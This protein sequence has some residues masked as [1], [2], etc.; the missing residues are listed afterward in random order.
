MI[1]DVAT[2]LAAC[3]HVERSEEQ[4]DL[5]WALVREELAEM[6]EA[7]KNHDYV[8]ELDGIADTIWVLIGYA[9]SKGYNLDCAWKEV[10]RSNHAKI[11]PDGTVKRR[12]DNKIL[13]P[14]GWTPPNIAG[15][16]K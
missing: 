1:N 2:F 6:C 14:E 12:H 8:E 16:F 4:A 13:K 10:T 7:K 3:G 15:C 5:Y 9:I 11:S